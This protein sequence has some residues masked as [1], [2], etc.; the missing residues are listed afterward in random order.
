M[1][2]IYT[3]DVTELEKSDLYRLAYERA[4]PERREKADKLRFDKGR[5]LCVGAEMLLLYGRK[6]LGMDTTPISY[7][8]GS[9]G[10]PYL[11]EA[12]YFN[13][14]HSGDRVLCAISSKEV[15][16]DVERIKERRTSVAGHFFCPEESEWLEAQK[17]PEEKRDLFFRLWTAKE[18]FI[19]TTGE[20]MKLPLDAFCLYP[21]LEKG[22]LHWEKDQRTYYFRELALGEGYKGTVCGLDEQILTER[23]SLEWVK[24]EDILT[25]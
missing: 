2:K 6:R 9:N 25:A 10:K 3:A 7:H 11:S 4:T 13:L 8:Y 12:L 20:G 14:S 16:C 21:A 19:K 18:S 23:E 22:S 1:I 5:R 24:F 17:T 15:G